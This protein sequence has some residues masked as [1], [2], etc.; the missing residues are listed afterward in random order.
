MPKKN[1]KKIELSVILPCRNEEKAL[2]FC[3]KEIKKTLKENKIKAEIIVSDSSWD[4]SPKIAKG[5]KVKL[6]RHGQEGYGLA[7]LEAFKIAQGKYIFMAD[8]DCTYDFKEI[9]RF[10]S[11]LKKGQ[12]FVIGNRF[13]GKIEEGAMPWLHQHIGN[14]LFSFL[15]RLFFKIKIKDPH[16][17]MRAIR[18]DA[19]EKLNLQ[20]KG[21]EFASEMVI[22]AAKKNLKIKELEIN[23]Y[24]RKGFSKL[25]SFSDGWKHLRFMLLYSPMFLFFI[26]GLIIF[27]MGLAGMIIFYFS[28]PK[29]SGLQFYFHPMFLFLAL[30]ASGYQI[31]IFGLF[32]KSYSHIHLEEPSVFLEKLYKYLTIERVGT[33]GI[34]VCLLGFV[35][36]FYIFF[37][38]IFSGLSALD[39][40]KNALLGV[41]F[42]ILGIQTIFSSFMLSILGIKK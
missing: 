35:I 13:G 9:P 26:P 39:E 12:D 21:M 28:S 6:L 1:N 25:H 32:A 42:I 27:S 19:L 15:F 16:C 5:N 34:A 14:P 18:K 24:K 7:Y 33:L 17:G 31:I 36:F 20:T 3:L 38:W 30:L 11:Q 4:N 10:L 29:I 40:A 41:S 37:K 22:K 23:Y 2:D 8:S